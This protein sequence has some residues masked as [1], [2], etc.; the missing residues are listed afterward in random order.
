VTDGAGGQARG[1][2]GVV[3]ELGDGTVTLDEDPRWSVMRSAPA[4]V[5]PDRAHHLLVLL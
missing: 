4:A 1:H 2:W 3:V 5:V